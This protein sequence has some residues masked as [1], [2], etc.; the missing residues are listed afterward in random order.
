MKLSKTDRIG[1]V[2]FAATVIGTGIM[3]A[4]HVLWWALD[5]L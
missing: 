4:S 5:W 3:W 2:L 1:L